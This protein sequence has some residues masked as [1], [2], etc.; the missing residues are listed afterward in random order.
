M[1]PA[2][3]EDRRPM[4]SAEKEAFSSG[5]K[6]HLLLL[7]GKW[8]LRV[9]LA[10]LRLTGYSLITKQYAMAAGVPYQPTLLLE[11]RGARTG[12]RRR[13]GLPYF[14]VGDDL[15]VRGTHG[16]GPT[17]PHWVDNVRKTRDVEIRI[18]RKRHAVVAEVTQGEERARIFEAIA[19]KDPSMR[20]YQ[21]MAAPRDIPLVALRGAAKG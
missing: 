2:G 13:C 16:G 21:E 8:G 17:D 9:D 3:A 5:G 12:K 18:L 14:R 4:T 6:R 1:P 20:R 10:I 15:V 11:T 19:R 7:H